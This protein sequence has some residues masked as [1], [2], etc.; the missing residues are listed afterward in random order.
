METAL[1]G[2]GII[3]ATKDVQRQQSR[4]IKLPLTASKLNGGKVLKENLFI[5]SRVNRVQNALLFF[6]LVR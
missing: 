5:L 4:Q 1:T 6:R 3:I 2:V